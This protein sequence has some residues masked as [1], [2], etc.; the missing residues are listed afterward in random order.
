ME[1]IVVTLNKYFVPLLGLCCLVGL[2]LISRYNFLLFHSLVEMFS[3]VI[4]AG[5]FII[6]WNSRHIVDHHYWLLMGVTALSVGVIELLHTLAYKGMGVF[7]GYDANPPTQL[8]IA[9]QYLKSISFLIAPNFL[10]R[11]VKARV[12]LLGYILVTTLLL[13]SIFYWQNFPTCFVEGQG[14]TPFKV[15]SEYIISLILLAA[16]GVLWRHRAEFD[17]HVFRLLIGSIILSI[18]ADMAF[19]LYMDPYGLSNQAGHFLKVISFYLVY[20]A[21][22]ETGLKRPY[23]LL[24]RTLKQ[25][26]AQMRHNSL[27]DTLTGLPNRA[28]F[29]DRLTVAIEQ[30]R[31]DKDYFFAVLFIDLDHFKLINDNLGHLVG[32]QLLIAVAERLKTC[33]RP[34]GDMVARLGGDEFTVLLDAVK[35]MNQV[36]HMAA[37]IQET[38]TRPLTLN[39]HEIKPALS[40]GMTTCMNH[41]ARPEDLLRDADAAM[42]QAKTNRRG[43]SSLQRQHAY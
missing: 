43:R 13:G 17:P 6:A 38:V 7:P 23:D 42:Y 37:C 18:S 11:R 12:I 2:Y 10:R 33:V 16:I 27:H 25:S 35:D 26:E 19:T 31:L 4:S 34:T 3:I 24:F 39:E 40:I 30:A 41:Y 21:V 28:L 32:D 20:K 5:I 14:L 8:W 1:R 36:K 9:A 15:A 29:M 22:I